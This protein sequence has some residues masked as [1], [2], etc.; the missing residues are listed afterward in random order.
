MKIKELSTT[1]RHKSQYGYETRPEY[2]DKNFIN[3]TK[4]KAVVNK[5]K[6]S[7]VF[8]TFEG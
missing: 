8:K 3:N 1:Q 4:F 7:F 2:I 6:H 5:M